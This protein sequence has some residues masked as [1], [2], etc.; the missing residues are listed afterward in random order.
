MKLTMEKATAMMKRDGGSLDLRGTQ[1]TALPDNLTVGGSLD[2]RGTQ[3][4]A[5]PDNLTVGGWLYLS[6]TQIT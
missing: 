1:I 6:G 5:L 2:L 4:T 3:I